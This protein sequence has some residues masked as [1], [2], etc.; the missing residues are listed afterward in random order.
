MLGSGGGAG[1]INWAVW[2]QRGRR[3]RAG[4]G[5]GPQVHARRENSS[6]ARFGPF[7][8][9][10][11]L[12][13]WGGLLAIS[14]PHCCTEAAFPSRHWFEAARSDK[15]F[16]KKRKRNV[17]RREHEKWEMMQNS[18]RNPFVKRELMWADK[19]EKR[20]M[21]RLFCPPGGGTRAAAVSCVRRSLPARFTI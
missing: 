21:A 15:H 18:G 8:W 10:L 1:C 6:T 14:Q 9:R 11:R 13:S 7:L 19:S 4:G 20:W 2:G 3:R 5:D 12:I 17:S 16:L